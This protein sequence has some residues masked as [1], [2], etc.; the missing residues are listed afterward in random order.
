MRSAALVGALSLGVVGLSDPPESPATAALSKLRALAGDWKGTVQWTGARTDSG[1]MDAT[2]FVTGNGSAVVENLTVDG[3]P[4]MTSVYHLDGAD[5]RM[6]HYCGAQNQPRL[7][8]QRIDLARG[9]L[10]FS[11]VDMT[12]A[13]SPDAPHVHGVEIQFQDADHFLLTFLF[14]SG[15]KESRERIEL[16]RAGSRAGTG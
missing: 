1:K 4:V 5:L 12:N 3:V 15:G 2:Y 7:K 9:L 16:A 11:F 8:A 6:T 14:V 10:E 13:R